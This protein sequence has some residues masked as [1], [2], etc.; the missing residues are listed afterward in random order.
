[1]TRHFDFLWL[2]ALLLFLPTDGYAPC[3]VFTP[4]EE[5]LDGTGQRAFI[6]YNPQTQ[7]VDLVP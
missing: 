1:M 7:R 5:E 3:V 4:P 2:F 6:A